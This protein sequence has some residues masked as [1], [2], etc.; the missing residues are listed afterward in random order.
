MK[1]I[2]AGAAI[3][4]I[5]IIAA[6]FT[7]T[8]C[9]PPSLKQTIDDMVSRKVELLTPDNEAQLAEKTPE[10]T[11]SS[12]GD[13]ASYEVQLSIT[14]DFAD[15]VTGTATEMKYEI[16][17]PLTICDERYW[18]VRAIGADS[19]EGPWS[20]TRSFEIVVSESPRLVGS[21]N[22]RTEY[23]DAD[24]FSVAVDGDYVYVPLGS[25]GDG[26]A[27]LDIST[28]SAPVRIGSFKP[29]SGRKAYHADI[30]GNYVYCHE[31]DTGALLHVIDISDPANPV[32]AGSSPGSALSSGMVATVGGVTVAIQGTTLQY[33]ST[34]NPA[35]ISIGDKETLPAE[36]WIPEVAGFN[37]CVVVEKKGLYIYGTYDYGYKGKYSIPDI[38]NF[39]SGIAGMGNYV[40]LAKE[41]LLIIDCT[42]PSSPQLAATYPLN[43]YDLLGGVE[44]SGHYLVG[45][46]GTGEGKLVVLDIQEPTAPVF[47]GVSDAAAG[48]WIEI[49][50]NYVIAAAYG[51]GVVNIIDL[52][53]ED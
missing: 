18:R 23:P 1:T 30:F 8:T 38:T 14:E 45:N 24:P 52:V 20:E 42:D 46:V 6:L 22:F 44:I 5:M 32:L 25:A 31:S 2:P 41:D 51:T 34:N 15:P 43:D 21:Y 17:D 11:W 29:P 12:L 40:Y 39:F 4:F 47:A 35:A 53:P 36:G 26:L 19:T 50:G 9:E 16:P 27:V 13:A 3:G 10:L 33:Y 37:F 48:G 28:P 49:S 7:L